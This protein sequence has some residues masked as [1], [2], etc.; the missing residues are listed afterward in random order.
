[1]FSNAHQ[2]SVVLNRPQQFS[3]AISS[4]QKQSAGFNSSKKRPAGLSINQLLSKTF[5][6]FL[7]SEK[8]LAGLSGTQKRSA[9][10]GSTVPGI[11][12]Q[13]SVALNSARQHS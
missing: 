7:S 10:L 3:V 13:H 4:S 1:M 6:R 12:Q 2:Y 9:V 5:L 8:Y 11:A